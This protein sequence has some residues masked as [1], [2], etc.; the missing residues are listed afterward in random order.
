MAQSSANARTKGPEGRAKCVTEWRPRACN[1]TP[2]SAARPRPAQPLGPLRHT[3]P[4]GA[5][6]RGRLAFNAYED[7]AAT[8]E[9]EEGQSEKFAHRGRSSNN[10]RRPAGGGSG[11]AHVRRRPPVRARYSLRALTL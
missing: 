5:G 9:G 1:S 3:R 2:A 11:F 4:S 7:S 8:D 10:T 6:Q